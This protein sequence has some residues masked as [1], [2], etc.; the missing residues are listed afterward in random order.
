MHPRLAPRSLRDAG[1]EGFLTTKRLLEL[2]WSPVPKAAVCQSHKLDHHVPCRRRPGRRLLD[3]Q[4]NFGE[5]QKS[6]A[7]PLTGF[8]NRKHVRL[9]LLA[10]CLLDALLRGYE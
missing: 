7:N 3:G 6:Y 5:A 8:S 10:R 4:K 2:S 1:F 9:G